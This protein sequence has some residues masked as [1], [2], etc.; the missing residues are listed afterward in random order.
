MTTTLLPALALRNETGP[1]WAL[2]FFT[3]TLNKRKDVT[4]RVLLVF[5]LF[6]RLSIYW[7]SG[8]DS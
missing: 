8:A 7:C 5:S 1:W 2:T 3:E 4:K 6:I